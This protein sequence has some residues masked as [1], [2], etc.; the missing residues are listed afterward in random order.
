[1]ARKKPASGMIVQVV[2]VNGSCFIAFGF[3]SLLI[4]NNYTKQGICGQFRIDENQ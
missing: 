2:K 4:S 1:M 3:N